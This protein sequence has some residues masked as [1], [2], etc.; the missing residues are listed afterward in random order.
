MTD[1][2]LSAS[3]MLHRAAVILTKASPE[4]HALYEEIDKNLDMLAGNSTLRVN[5]KDRSEIEE[6]DDDSWVCLGYQRSYPIREVTGRRGPSRALGTL[7]IIVD[8]NMPNGLAAQYGEALFVI[9]WAGRSDDRPW[10]F[11]QLRVPFDDHIHGDG[12]PVLQWIDDDRNKES[13]S[14]NRAIDGSWFYVLPLDAMSRRET[15]NTKMII[16][17]TRLLNGESIEKAFKGVADVFSF[18]GRGNQTRRCSTH[19]AP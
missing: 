13:I 17:V 15:I 16:P 7:S 6:Y 19:P 10:D 18:V 14:Q 1:K 11:E 3:V 5:S 4:F 12:S 2:I 8:L 9:G